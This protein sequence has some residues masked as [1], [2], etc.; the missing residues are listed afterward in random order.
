VSPQQT[1]LTASYTEQPDHPLENGPA[2]E[3]ADLD[4]KSYGEDVIGLAGPGLEDSIELQYGTSVRVLP[5]RTKLLY[6]DRSTR[7]GNTE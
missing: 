1:F 2:D 3:F 7:S 4:L 6:Y 5:L